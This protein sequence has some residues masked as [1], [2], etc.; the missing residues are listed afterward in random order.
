MAT[1]TTRVSADITAIDTTN[2]SSGL[3]NDICR[4]GFGW[5]WSKSRVWDHVIQQ[6]HMLFPCEGAS[7]TRRRPR[8]K[9][10]RCGLLLDNDCPALFHMPTANDA[11][12]DGRGDSV[13]TWKILKRIYNHLLVNLR[14]SCSLQCMWLVVGLRCHAFTNKLSQHRS[15]LYSLVLWTCTVPPVR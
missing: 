12:T 13:I 8:V 7:S 14:F 6:Y 4:S 2:W 9:V 10:E 11:K 1:S 3:L 15:R 5:R